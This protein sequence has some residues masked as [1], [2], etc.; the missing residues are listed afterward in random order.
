MTFLDDNFAVVMF[1][2]DLLRKYQSKADVYPR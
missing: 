1:L 2:E